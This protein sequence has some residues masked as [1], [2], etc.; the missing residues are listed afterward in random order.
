MMQLSRSL[1]TPSDSI[2][3]DKSKRNPVH[4]TCRDCLRDDLLHL[5][6][7]TSPLMMIMRVLLMGGKSC[8][9]CLGKPLG[10]IPFTKPTQASCGLP[11]TR[12][13]TQSIVPKL[14]FKGQIQDYQ[15][16]GSQQ[17]QT[18]ESPRTDLVKLQGQ[19]QAPT[20]SRVPSYIENTE[21]SWRRANVR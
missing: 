6:P 7:K 21:V 4:I 8:Q 14:A 5:G 16:N 1:M 11:Q 10:I 13:A 3:P 19:S 12:I 17:H 2:G 15:R 9:L 20:A 18:L